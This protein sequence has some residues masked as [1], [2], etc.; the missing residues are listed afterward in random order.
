MFS[1]RDFSIWT[2]NFF[3]YKRGDKEIEKIQRVVLTEEEK[4]K[5]VLVLYPTANDFVPEA[6]LTYMKLNYQNFE[7]IIL[8]DSSKDSEKKKIDLFAK[9]YNLKVVRRNDRVGYKAGNY[10][11]FLQKNKDYDYFVLL[12]SDEFLSPNFITDCLKYFKYYDNVGIVQANHKAK[13]GSNKFVK[14][15]IYSFNYKKMLSE[16]FKNKFGMVLCYG[17]GALISKECYEKINGGFPPIFAD[18]WGISMEARKNN[19]LTVFAPNIVCEEILPLDLVSW[20]KRQFRWTRGQLQ[21]IKRYFV[22][23]MTNKFNL[24]FCE[25]M[26]IVCGSFL[27]PLISLGVINIINFTFF[28]YICNIKIIFDWWFVML[29]VCSFLFIF[30]SDIYFG[31][32][33]NKE[34]NIKQMIISII[35]YFILNFTMAFMAFWSLLTAL[36]GKKSRFVVTNKFQTKIKFYQLFTHNWKELT[37][38]FI[39]LILAIIFTDWKHI[40]FVFFSLMPFF[41]LPY[42][43]WLGNLECNDYENALAQELKL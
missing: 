23:V 19:F 5:K 17:H 42:L 30:I 8:D 22:K 34:W 39:L 2:V 18:D 31:L 32:R 35:H 40:I 12:D 15:F 11:N 27:A 1:L 41:L 38:A 43:T 29:I 6:V 10:N 20:K 7:I 14:K 3:L 28:I 24:S 25:K 26:D 9:K 13:K 21:F 16:H 33:K 36:F 4:Q 37:F